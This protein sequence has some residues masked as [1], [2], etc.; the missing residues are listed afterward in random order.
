MGNQHSRERD[1]VPSD[2]VETR[3]E[4]LPFHDDDYPIYFDSISY[5]DSISIILTSAMSS[6]VC[7]P[8]DMSIWLNEF[9]WSREGL[10]EIANQHQE[11]DTPGENKLI[12]KTISSPGFEIWEMSGGNW[13]HK[14]QHFCFVHFLPIAGS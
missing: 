4:R 1:G 2:G 12:L 6:S 11:E 14:R 7:S 9:D 5:I 13:K 8:A 3:I 10:N